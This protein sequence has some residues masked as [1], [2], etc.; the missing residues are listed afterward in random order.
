M[1]EELFPDECSLH[2]PVDAHGSF[3][4]QCGSR[5]SVGWVGRANVQFLL[6]YS[7]MFIEF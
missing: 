3:L 5:G 7:V 4:W 6:K 2:H 1:G